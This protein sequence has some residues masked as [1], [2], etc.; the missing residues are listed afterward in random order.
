[1]LRIRRRLG[2][3]RQ[4][5]P[6]SSTP[7]SPTGARGMEVMPQGVTPPPIRRASATAVTVG[8]VAQ[9]EVALY[10]GNMDA[11]ILARQASRRLTTLPPHMR[12]DGTTMTCSRWRLVSAVRAGC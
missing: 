5:D 4:F 2:I 8:T 6:K 7:A 1:M 11:V 12:A 3:I 10:R 9:I